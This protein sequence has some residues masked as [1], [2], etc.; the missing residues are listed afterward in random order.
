MVHDV[1][2]SRAVVQVFVS[3]NGPLTVIP[4]TCNGPVPLLCTV[5]L[6]VVLD[7][8]RTCEE[9]DKLDGVTVAAGVVPVPI[10]TTL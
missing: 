3:L 7:V 1:P 2:G 4:V 5:I 6:R 8:P 9:K 10:S